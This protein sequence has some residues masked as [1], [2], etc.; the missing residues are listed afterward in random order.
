MHFKRA[1]AELAPI[2]RAV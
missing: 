1:S 2:P